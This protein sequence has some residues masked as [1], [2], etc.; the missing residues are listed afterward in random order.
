M[1]RYAG[2]TED[3]RGKLLARALRIRMVEE[4][5]IELYPSDVIQS[6]VHLSIGQELHTVALASLLTPPGD[7]IFTTYRSH[8]AYLASGGDLKLM[9]A[10]LYGKQTG[11]S[12]GK[13]GSMHLCHPSTGLM[14]SSAIVGAVYSHA[15]GAAY[16]D[17]IA[18][19]GR[20]VLC[21]TGEGA[22]E[23]GT[24]HECLNF[25]ALKGLPLVYIIENNGL[26][27]NIPLAKRQSY[28]LRDLVKAYGI[29]HFH[30]RDSFDMDEV[31]TLAAEAFAAARDRHAPAVLE[32]D[33]YRY[34]EH[35]G[36]C[37]DHDKKYR[38]PEELEDWRRRDP[39]IN[40]QGLLSLHQSA[41]AEEI[42]AAVLF[43]DRSPYPS[44]GDLTEDVY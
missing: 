36:I 33:T 44:L 9:F 32:I 30:A 21:I 14:G 19:N 34:K 26:A 42:D 22:T 41:I 18:K 38:D 6:P 43:A 23:E 25:T 17:K 40:D 37:C 10:E 28:R 11:V 20:V 1:T 15:V 12:K 39:L 35:V 16:A 7:R 13:A 24:F 31:M 4:R 3:L 5:I 27:I 2:L 29:S 8:A